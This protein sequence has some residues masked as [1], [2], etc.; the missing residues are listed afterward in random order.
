MA[1]MKQFNRKASHGQGVKSLSL[2][3]EREGVVVG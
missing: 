2:L 1:E 3:G